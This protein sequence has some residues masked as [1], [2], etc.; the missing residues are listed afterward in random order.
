MSV[1]NRTYG[2]PCHQLRARQPFPS[3]R[4]PS[5]HDQ[6][7]PVKSTWALAGNTI[8]THAE[9]SRWKPRS[10]RHPCRRYLDSHWR[11]RPPA[12]RHWRHARSHARIPI[13]RLNRADSRSQEYPRARISRQR[14]ETRARNPS[15]GRSSRRRSIRRRA[16]SPFRIDGWFRG[17]AV[18]LPTCAIGAVIRVGIRWHPHQAAGEASFQ[19][20][21]IA[22]PLLAGGTRYALAGTTTATQLSPRRRKPCAH[23][24]PSR[25]WL[26]TEL[27]GRTGTFAPRAPTD[28]SNRSTA[29]ERE[30][31]MT[32]CGSARRECL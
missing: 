14:C 3:L 18:A 19:I 9:A 24:Q 15:R 13:H 4:K 25:Y 10:Q 16:R 6:S 30:I 11:A 21:T 1:R 20:A 5:A 28:T 26:A 12:R 32:G 2:D 27:A 8:A 29:N 31:F 23:S 22:F 17:T 7:L